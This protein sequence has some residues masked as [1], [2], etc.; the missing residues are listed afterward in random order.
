MLTLPQD[1]DELA[2]ASET[3]YMLSISLYSVQSSSSDVKL[4]GCGRQV[5]DM[6]GFAAI[7]TEI[8]DL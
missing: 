5:E 8:I 1:S 3:E 7:V 4:E 2:E 6:K